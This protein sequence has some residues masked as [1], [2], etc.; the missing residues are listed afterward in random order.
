MLLETP[1]FPGCVVR[2]RVVGVIEG[3]QT[4]RSGTTTANPR[5]I[6]VATKS[7]EYAAVRRLSE[8]PPALIDEITHFFVSYN[9]ATGKSYRP[10]GA[11]G[12]RR[13]TAL[14]EAAIRR[15]QNAT[16]RRRKRG[17]ALRTVA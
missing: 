7:T 11:F 2:G 14:I 10:A 17:R 6:A 1:T 13:A 3:Q 8:L 16:A 9:D 12:P 4:G 5:L 15:R